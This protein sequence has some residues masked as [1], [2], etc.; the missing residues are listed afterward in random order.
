M[1]QQSRGAPYPLGSDP[2]NAAAD[3]QALSLWVN[4]RPGVATL[5]TTQ[6]NALSGSDRWDGR[7]VL[8][9]TLDRLF[10]WD[11]G[12]ASWVQSADFAE[13][14]ALLATSG[15]PAQDAV[16]ASR[17]VATSAARSDHIH[18]E[19]AVQTWTP[20][21]LGGFTFGNAT[22]SGRYILQGKFCHFWGRV[23]LGTT[24]AVTGVI[25]GTLPVN[26]RTPTEYFTLTAH[27]VDSGANDY[28]IWARQTQ[29]NGISLYG[30][31]ASGIYSPAY[32]FTLGVGDSFEWRGTY[33]TA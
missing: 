19:P 23:V 15:T 22:A 30:Q 21:T 24:S 28:E 25:I 3:I 32:P 16:T 4:D 6:R 12:L 17:G 10:R 20:T 31:T 33:E 26:G 1:A 7:M 13:I 5:T 9:T 11:A 18:P 2:N 8:D 29:V 14:A 27:L